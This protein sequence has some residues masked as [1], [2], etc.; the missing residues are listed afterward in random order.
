MCMHLSQR[1][2][3]QDAAYL[4]SRKHKHTHTHTDALARAQAHS[5]KNT[6]VHARTATRTCTQHNTLRNALRSLS[7]Q[8]HRLS[9]N[10]TARSHKHSAVQVCACACTCHN[11]ATHRMRHACCQE[12]TNRH[13]DAQA[14]AQVQSDKNTS[15]HARA[16]SRMPVGPPL[17]IVMHTEKHSAQ[18]VHAI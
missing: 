3:T 17:L 13:I 1:S 11:A 7:A 10:P 14:R 2:N 9:N 12:S 18:R 8:M 15:V 16:M 6:R 5:D 4:L